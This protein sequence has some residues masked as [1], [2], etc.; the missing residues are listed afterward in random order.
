MGYNEE[1]GG[2]F[3]PIKQGFLVKVCVFAHLGGFFCIHARDVKFHPSMFIVFV[4]VFFIM[5]ILLSIT[6]VYKV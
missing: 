3:E 6:M 5:F 1:T 4:I 2:R